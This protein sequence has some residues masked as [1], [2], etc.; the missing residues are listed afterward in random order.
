[1]SNLL[2]AKL[3]KGKSTS[4]QNEKISPALTNAIT[5]G[6]LRLCQQLVERGF[7]IDGTCECGCTVLVKAC[8]NNQWAISSYLLQIGAPV[9]GVACAKESKFEGLTAFQLVALNGELEL[10]EKMFNQGPLTTEE[11]TQAFYLAS[12]RGRVHILRFLLEHAEDK[13]PLLEARKRSSQN[14]ENE[15]QFLYSGEL[16]IRLL[17]LV[18]FTRNVEAAEILLRA[19]ADLEA[20]DEE[21][22]TALQVASLKGSN[23]P[24][25]DLLVKAGANLNTRG[26]N[27]MTPLMHAAR[28]QH[29]L[30]NVKHLMSFAQGA[31]DLQATDR[32]GGT[33]LQYAIEGKNIDAATFLI[34]AGLDPLQVDKFGC[35]PIQRALRLRL[36]QFTLENLPEVDTICSPVQGSILNT[37]AFM[38]NEVVVTELLKRV[39]EKD[40][41][42]YVNL[43]CDVGTPLY[44][45]AYIME[46]STMERLIEKGA[47]IN[48]VGGPAGSALMA[49]CVVGNVEGVRLLL[50]K[51]A[52]LECTKF[53]GTT[54]T[55]EEAA[56][57]HENVLLLLRRYKEKGAH[58]LDEHIPAKTAD[59]S[60]LDKFM[61]VYK[62]WNEKRLRQRGL[63]GKDQGK[64]SGDESDD[65]METTNSLVHHEDD[66][67]DQEK[68]DEKGREGNIEITEDDA[69]L[70]IVVEK[71]ET[72]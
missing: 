23:K 63:D 66:L 4:S 61:V 37:A 10:F 50:K 29:G 25:V 9:K 53:D 7:T 65:W 68:D 42:E 6:D 70:E 44:C 45:S 30:K 52:E 1:M 59:I 43:P 5:S 71:A 13:R 33:A 41:V 16:Y 36:T 19:G 64:L 20:R 2:S 22:M 3:I 57:H 27:G 58:A 14:I 40:Q 35:S 56:Q 51:G 39:P 21:G 24:M 54:I 32:H 38:G 31:L 11:K 34:E 72:A 15:K 46:I 55:A 69:K 28:K 26:F 49:A 48:F 18:V 17:H 62:K 67:E 12:E 60:E 8:L 47:Q